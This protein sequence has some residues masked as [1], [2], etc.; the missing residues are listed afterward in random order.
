MVFGVQ[1]MPGAC[2]EIAGMTIGNL[3]KKKEYLDE[4]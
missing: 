1:R 2:S 3:C 4:V